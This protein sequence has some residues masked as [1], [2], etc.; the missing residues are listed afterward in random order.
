M[1]LSWLLVQEGDTGENVRS[2]Q[3]LL[4]AHGF[5]L[6]V[7]GSFGPQTEG[8][9]K[10]FQEDTGLSVDGIVGPYTWN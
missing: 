5:S 6:T 10:Y 4:D 7:D 3:Y 9:V 2:V 8:A 1:A